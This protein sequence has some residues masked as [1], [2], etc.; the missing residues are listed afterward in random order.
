M[1]TDMRAFDDCKHEV[2]TLVDTYK[3]ME[4]SRCEKCK[5]VRVG[6]GE[7]T[8]WGAPHMEVVE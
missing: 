1:K 6:E 8:I 3:G 5:W 7:D 4:I 2:V